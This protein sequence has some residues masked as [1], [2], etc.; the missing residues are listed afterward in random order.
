MARVHRLEY[1][2][3]TP[4]SCYALWGACYGAGAVGRLIDVPVLL[5]VREILL[6]PAR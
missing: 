5:A 2:L 6:S 3:P 4:L 1:P